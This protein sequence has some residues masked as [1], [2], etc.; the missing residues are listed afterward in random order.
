MVYI[1]TD[2][3]LL[4]PT[5]VTDPE[6]LKRT[7]LRKRKQKYRCHVAKK[8][9]TFKQPSQQL[10]SYSTNRRGNA[11]VNVIPHYPPPE[12]IRAFDEEID[13]RPFPQ[14]GAF[15]TTPFNVHWAIPVNEGTP[16]WRNK[17]AFSLKTMKLLAY[18][19][20]EP[21]KSLVSTPKDKS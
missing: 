7:T 19:S 17:L 21:I 15:Y 12:P 16:P 14:G 11:L 8:G 3:D 5:Q 2:L 20:L 6:V 9:S 13:E 1:Y 4:V 18:Y 10:G